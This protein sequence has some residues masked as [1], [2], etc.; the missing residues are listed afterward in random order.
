M[1]QASRQRLWLIPVLLLAGCLGTPTGTTRQAVNNAKPKAV[2]PSPSPVAGARTATAPSR[3]AQP[4]A[5]VSA[6][7]PVTAAPTQAPTAA[8]APTVA[9]SAKPPL[10]RRYTEDQPDDHAG[11]QIHMVYALPKGAP[12]EELDRKGAI[13]RAVEGMNAWLSRKGDGRA[14]RFDT[15]QN[16]PDVTFVRLRATDD[17]LK[18]GPGGGFAGILAELQ[19]TALFK[20]GKVIAVFY[21]ADGVRDDEKHMGKAH[22]GFGIAFLKCLD[23]F[24]LKGAVTGAAWENVMLHEIVHAIGMNESTEK[25]HVFDAPN[26]LMATSATHSTNV[27]LDLNNDDYFEHGAREHFDLSKSLFLKRPPADARPPKGWPYAVV[28]AADGVDPMATVALPAVQS[29]GALEDALLKALNAERTKAGVT[30]LTVTGSLQMVAR[31]TADATARAAAPPINMAARAGRWYGQVTFSA[32]STGPVDTSDASV[33]GLVEQLL[34]QSL[35]RTQLL[36]AGATELAVGAVRIDGNVTVTVAV[37]KASVDVRRLRLGSTPQGVYAFS[38]EVR[39]LKTLAYPLLYTKSGGVT[40]PFPTP[41]TAEWTSFVV[42]VPRDQTAHYVELRH[43]DRRVSLAFPISW[44]F[45]GTKPPL[46]ALELPS[47][48]RPVLALPAPQPLPVPSIFE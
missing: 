36:D 43:G 41:L 31:A 16:E 46:E 34:S 9:P 42:D 45:D 25:A 17:E 30:A 12:D 40:T 11:Y 20:P 39:A 28:P 37:G 4:T 44:I 21:G 27:L 14:L 7:P 10:R 23:D 35:R 19:E 29:D 24:S 18:A 8:P 32:S 33:Q 13:A 38:G 47:L 48:T 6:P 22:Q 15:Y 1:N 3:T 5:R 2:R 26:D